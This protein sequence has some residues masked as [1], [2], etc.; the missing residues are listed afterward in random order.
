MDL[1]RGKTMTEPAPSQG[2]DC[3]YLVRKSNGDAGWV[4]DWCAFPTHAHAAK[5]ARYCSV[6]TAIDCFFPKSALDAERARAE[7]AEAGSGEMRQL[8]S[9]CSDRLFRYHEA[10]RMQADYCD[11]CDPGSM[12]DQILVKIDRALNASAPGKST[13]DELRRL[14]EAAR[15]VVERASDCTLDDPLSVA[16]G[17]LESVLQAAQPER[18]ERS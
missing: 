12:D 7:Q 2:D 14:R 15:K 11:I 18:A 1:Q 4:Y 6:E 13:A 8:L 16:I 17:Q 10:V 5:S 9:D 3:I